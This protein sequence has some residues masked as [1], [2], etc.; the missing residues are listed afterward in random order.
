VQWASDNGV[1]IINAVD[2]GEQTICCVD[3]DTG[4]IYAANSI[5]TTTWEK[6]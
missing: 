6:Q 5:V 2:L 4:D 3:L 1:D